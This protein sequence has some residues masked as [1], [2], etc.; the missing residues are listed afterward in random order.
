[1][2]ADIIFG[3]ILPF[4]LLVVAGYLI[5]THRDERVI[6]WAEIA[7]RAA[8]QIY[9]ESGAGKEK[10]AYVA[11]WIS[12]KFKIPK[13]DLKIIIEDAVFKLNS[14]KNKGSEDGKG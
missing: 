1:M 8:E 2:I 12:A 11:D 13:E 10:F 5:Y 14:E 7:V 9:K 6:K 4:I 3:E